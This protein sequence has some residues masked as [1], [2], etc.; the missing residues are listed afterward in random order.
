MCIRDSST[1]LPRFLFALGIREVGES[2][3]AA[4]ARHFG[5]LDALAAA[6]LEAVQQVPDVGPV[7]ASRVVEFFADR[8]NRDEL[9]RLRE[10]GVRWPAE[11]KREVGEQPLAGLTFV[12]TGTLEALSRD[13]AEDALRALGAKAAGSVSKKTS[14]LVAGT[15]A[16]SKLRKAEE[17]GVPVLDEAALLRVLQTKR[18]PG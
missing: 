3:A 8:D 2:T 14:Y 17:L 1:T 10:A 4:L 13:A 6:D 5:D 15:D 11:A 16:G 12:L 9:D 7:V 18:P